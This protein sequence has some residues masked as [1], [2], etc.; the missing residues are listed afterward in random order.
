VKVEATTRTGPAAVFINT[1]KAHDS[2]E[3]VPMVIEFVD[4]RATVAVNFAE[5]WNTDGRQHC[6]TATPPA[7]LFA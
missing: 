4:E 2:D 3:P 6:R 1:P 7:S 5:E